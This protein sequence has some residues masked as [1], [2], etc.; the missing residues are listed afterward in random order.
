MSLTPDQREAVLKY[1][2]RT[3]ADLARTYDVDRTAAERN[4]SLGMRIVALLGAAALTGA[5]VL[6]FLDSWGSLTSGVQLAIAWA[7]PLVA[8]G[9]A[10]YAARRERTLYFTAILSFLAAGCFVLD[11]SVVGTVLNAR[12]SSTPL[13]IWA[14]FAALLAYAWDLTWLIALAAIS[15]IAFFASTVVWLAGFPLDVS[16]ARPE[17]ILAP[18][19]AVFATSMLGINQVRSGFPVALRRTG[20]AA[21]FIALLVLSEVG[22]LSFLPWQSST[23]R[24]VYQVVG[25]FFAGAAIWTGVRCGW[26]DTLNMGA[27]VFGF[28][29]L[30]R[31]V[32]WWWEWMPTSL[33]FFLVAATAIGCLLLLRRIRA[34]ARNAS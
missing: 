27:A 22:N 16:L 11:V 23:I 30:L 34:R 20:L 8:L 15:V 18:A 7:A 29:L 4:L 21:F 32:D 6:F 25:F 1:H 33:F 9:A 19:A 5:V 14:L 10:A 13:L 31:Y 26:P 3:L 2:D 28:L 12:P 24:H 17:T